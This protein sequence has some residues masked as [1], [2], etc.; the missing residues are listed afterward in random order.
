MADRNVV[1]RIA[2]N[3]AKARRDADKLADSLDRVTD[4]T[5]ELDGKTAAGGK[6]A[7][8]ATKKRS[9]ATQEMVRQAKA[10][11]KADTSSVASTTALTGVTNTVTGALKRRAAAARENNRVSAQ[12]LVND[13]AA[14]QVTAAVAAAQ[15]KVGRAELTR[16][17]ATLALEAAQN[18]LAAAES[19][20]GKASK[21]YAN[22]LLSVN[23]RQLDV[24]TSSNG[25]ARSLQVLERATESATAAAA[26]GAGVFGRFASTLKRGGASFTAFPKSLKGMAVG[27]AG[28]IPKFALIS[29]GIGYLITAISAL[30]AGVIGLIGPLG[31]LGGVLASLPQLA[32]VAAGA[33]GT[34]L[35]A[36]SGI[37][38]ALKQGTAAQKEAGQAA[39]DAAKAEKQAARA[40][41]LAM[42]GVR[43]AREAAADSARNYRR[44]LKD[45]TEAVKDAKDA[46]VDAGKRLHDVRQEA[47]RDLIDMQANLRDLALAERGAAISVEEARRKLQTVLADPGA[48]PL[49]KQAAQLAYDEALARMS[50]VEKEKARA[51]KDTAEAQKKGVKG[52][53]SVVEARDAEREAIEAVKDAEQ[54]LSDTKREAT[55]SARD[56][57]EAIA[58]AQ[59]NLKEAQSAANDQM[60]AG[61]AAADSY[62]AALAELSPAG[63]AF[64]QTLLGMRD[65]MK[66]LKFAA[67]EGLLPGLGE[68]LT[69]MLKLVPLAEKG[70]F[71]FGQTIAN[72]AKKAANLLTSDA[73]MPMWSRLL[74]S[75]TRLLELGGEAFLNLLEAVVYLMDAAAPFTEW[76]ARTVVGWTEYWKEIAKAGN[77]TGRT[78][79]F[80]DRT[81]GVLKLLGGAFKNLWDVL[82]NLATAS[83]GFSKWLL[84][85]F[86][87]ITKGWA[88]WT[89]SIKGQN[90]LKEWFDS[91]KKPLSAMSSLL[92][93]LTRMFFNLGRKNGDDLAYLLSKVELLVPKF[94]ELMSNLQGD[95]GTALVDFLGNILDILITLTD[96]SSGGLTS[97]VETLNVFAEALNKILQNEGVMAVLK[98][99]AKILGVIAALRLV[100][101]VTGL[102][103]VFRLMGKLTKMGK[104]GEAGGGFFKKLTDG[105]KKL[106]PAM[107]SAFSKVQGIVW[108]G[109]A[110][111]SKAFS[112]IGKF[113]GT[114]VSKIGPALAKVGPFIMRIAG[115]FGTVLAKIGPLL[116][117]IVGVVSKAMLLIGRAMLANPWVL[118]VAALIVVAVLI[119]K[120]WDKIKAFVTKAVKAIINFIKKHWDII[121]WFGGPLV[122]LI[123]EVVKHWDKIKEVFFGALDAIKKFVTETIPKIADDIV[124]GIKAVPG[125]ISDLASNFT[126]AAGDILDAI[127]KGFTS[128]ADFAN[129]L[130]L[131]IYGAVK[132][133]IDS[134]IDKVNSILE[135]TVDTHIPG[136][137]KVTIDAPDLP[138]MPEPGFLK[139]NR[140]GGVPGQGNR[141]TVPALLTPGEFV[142]RKSA[143]QNLGVST[144]TALNEGRMKF[145]RGGAVPIDGGLKRKKKKLQEGVDGDAGYGN[146]PQKFAKG[147]QV[148][149]AKN[150]NKDKD[151]QKGVGKGKNSDKEK[152][153][154]G[155][156]QTKASILSKVLNFLRASDVEEK[157]YTGKVNLDKAATIREVLREA[158][159][160]KPTKET[161]HAFL[162]ANDMLQRTIPGKPGTPG[163]PGSS[164]GSPEL[165]RALAFANAQAGKPYVWG[166][167]GPGGYD[168]S[169]YQSAIINTL[170]GRSAY[171]RLFATGNMSSVLPGLGFKPGMGTSHDYSVGWFTGN[172]GHTGGTLGSLPVESTG[173]YVRNGAAARG[174]ENSMFPNKMHLPLGVS[175]TPGTAATPGTPSKTVGKEYNLGSK[176]KEGKYSVPNL[177][178]YVGA[179]SFEEVR[180][181]FDVTGKTL[182][183]L[184]DPNVE[185][186]KKLG[187]KAVPFLKGFDKAKKRLTGKET[188][189]PGGEE[190]GDPEGPIDDSTP[191][192][193][194]LAQTLRDIE[195]QNQWEGALT[196]FA[197]WGFTPLVDYMLGAGLDDEQAFASA[198]EASQSQPAASA[199]NDAL[200]AKGSF[201]QESLAGL[202]KMT[203]FITASTVDPTLRDLARH[204]GYSDLQTVQ[205]FEKALSSGKLSPVASRKSGRISSDIASYRAGT[206]YAN[207]GGEVP[208][209]GS[210]DTVPAMLTPGEFVIKKKAAKA[211]GI[212]N[213]WSLNNNAQHFAEGGMVM[214][215]VPT[216]VKGGVNARVMALSG[217]GGAGVV[218]NYDIDINNPVAEEGTRSMMK[219]LQRQGVLGGGS[220]VNGGG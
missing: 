197:E 134:A 90:E 204:L 121:K 47:R 38:E 3:F 136:V 111:M 17:K 148:K 188:V 195:K 162:K 137:G 92:G 173:T 5:E 13:R 178:K 144:V 214:G 159:A 216:N 123:T 41:K 96:G 212:Q 75:N 87:D 198:I 140:G 108:K 6:K 20:H 45:A 4:K 55:R 98:P 180:K 185:Q 146:A 176:L 52:T 167:V 54:A 156:T 174:A 211:L 93:A 109:I 119:Y 29:T 46:E 53:D 10:Q 199:L 191:L 71:M 44:A 205:L 124:A 217:S 68:A 126:D 112:G 49:A 76:L 201:D 66:R 88:D 154:K 80:L 171:S 184:V 131:Q 84:R 43:D 79:D 62:A 107:K 105:A 202:L 182:V 74:E 220:T 133:A 157:S 102:T 8:Q 77:E 57:A 1:W 141:D 18:R 164:S 147:G 213:L 14:V 122:V 63:Q 35:A 160:E 32:T 72:V 215:A 142:L 175:S 86:R 163:T 206:F 209:T 210:G 187:K 169:G 114:A 51:D 104:G 208:G 85:G 129:D 153:T 65:E 190:T 106:G 56:S 135:F 69:T 200:A 61:S 177:I 103:A 115:W 113:I 219:A 100:G 170:K 81:K 166:G 12:T 165:S 127:I 192:E 19:K 99:L 207:T 172:P 94:E 50:D 33:I 155:P 91:A 39:T 7:E 22:A 95:F 145:A 189:P 23:R 179:L 152:P 143:V 83:R 37:G 158:Y 117:R 138:H 60:Q 128:A 73:F 218:N 82:K 59:Y 64:V 110:L 25:H 130:A 28:L 78:A 89:G 118:L 42:R 183:D 58:D 15:E 70:L 193:R 181:H 132:G 161:L 9:A 31:Q 168:C 116:A 194:L 139:R 2:T 67:Q 16:Q 125:K 196:K 149:P 101:A 21:E 40:I 11:H 34:M 97:F 150:K 30:S 27:L 120:H 24:Q 203:S 26:G 151:K 186:F 36:F 48:D